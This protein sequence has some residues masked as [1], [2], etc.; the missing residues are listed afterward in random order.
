MACLYW[1]AHPLTKRKVPFIGPSSLFS[2]HAAGCDGIGAFLYTPE[3]LLLSLYIALYGHTRNTTFVLF[4]RFR[5]SPCP[6]RVLLFLYC[7]CIIKVVVAPSPCQIPTHQRP[8]PEAASTS[9]PR[10]GLSC[11]TAYAL[12]PPASS[13]INSESFSIP[14]QDKS[15]ESSWEGS[16]ASAPSGIFNHSVNDWVADFGNLHDFVTFNRNGRMV[17]DGSTRRVIGSESGRSECVVDEWM[18]RDEEELEL[19]R[20]LRKILMSVMC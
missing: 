2:L 5:N 18:A 20:R 8:L 16:S 14:H 7:A 6:S 10:S 1:E 3:W 17:M 15:C 9:I 12:L 11:F 4:Y 19:D 13:R